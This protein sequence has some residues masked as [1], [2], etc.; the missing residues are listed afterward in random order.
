M[1]QGVSGTAAAYYAV[2]F[3]VYAVDIICES[4]GCFLPGLLDLRI[5][6]AFK[7]FWSILCWKQVFPS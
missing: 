4:S 2:V 5:K 6:A 1:T 7:V 3:A